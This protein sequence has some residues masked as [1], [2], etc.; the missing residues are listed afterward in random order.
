MK[1]TKQILVLAN[2]YKEGGL[3]LAGKDLITK[4]WIRPVSNEEGNCISK[5]YSHITPLDTITIDIKKYS[6]L[7]EQPENYILNSIEYINSVS[8][9]N[10]SFLD[11]FVDNPKSLWCYGDRQD[12]E[13]HKNI[14]NNSYNH[15]SLYLIKVDRLTITV[16]PNYNGYKKLIG[17]FYYNKLNYKFSITDRAYCQYKNHDVG[18][19]MIKK[20]KYL[21][22]SLGA[23]FEATGHHYKLIAAIL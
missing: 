11:E 14:T 21:C 13:S 19:T 8:F 16:V 12:R 18:F 4:E 7:K 23:L 2:S 20:N 10:N 5:K 9:K 6:P 3:C 22:I 17:E 1:N 15:Q